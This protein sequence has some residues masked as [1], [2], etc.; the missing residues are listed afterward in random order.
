MYYFVCRQHNGCWVVQCKGHLENMRRSLVVVL[1][2]DTMN[3]MQR[4][5][6]ATVR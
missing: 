5:L 1:T 2:Q 6:P 3:D 4:L